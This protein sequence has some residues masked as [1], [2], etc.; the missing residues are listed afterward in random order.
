MHSAEQRRRAREV[1]QRQFEEQ[2]LA[3]FAGL[4][5]LQNRRVVIRAVLN[6]MVENGR[7][8]SESGYRQVVNIVFKSAAIQHLARNIVEPDTLTQ[9]MERFGGLHW[10]S[11]L[12]LIYG[13]D[14]RGPKRFEKNVG[15]RTLYLTRRES[16][17]LSAATCGAG[18][19]VRHPPAD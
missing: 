15:L 16:E 5:L 9:V 12:P 19:D 7:I 3:R 2:V 17:K 6:C 8:G 13:V 1:F 10:Y 4:H 14:F 18:R 11:N